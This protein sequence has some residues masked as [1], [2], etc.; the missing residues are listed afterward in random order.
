MAGGGATGRRNAAQTHIRATAFVVVS[1]LTAAGC[2]MPSMSSLP[3]IGEEESDRIDLFQVT[4]E[5]YCYRTLARVDCYAELQ[6]GEEARR[7]DWFDAPG[8]PRP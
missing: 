8:Y 4:A 6:P 3:F 2:A 7:M 5:K 1:A